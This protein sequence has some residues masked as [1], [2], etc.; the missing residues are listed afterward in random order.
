MNVVHNDLLFEKSKSN[1]EKE[2]SAVC[3]SSA[4]SRGGFPLSIVFQAGT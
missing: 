1:A 4:K 3:F 2:I